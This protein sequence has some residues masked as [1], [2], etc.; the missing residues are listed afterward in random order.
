MR[1]LTN[2]LIGLFVSLNLYGQTITERLVLTD[3]KDSLYLKSTD[4]SFD[5]E[6]N[7][8][9]VIKKNGQEYFVTNND[10][11]GG[12][13]FIVLTFGN[14][15]GVSCTN[16]YSAPQNKPYYYKNDK[17]VKVFGT[18]MEKIECFQTSNTRENIYKIN[19]I[20]HIQT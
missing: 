11:I 10:T 9:F 7:Y 13:K 4:I 12:F 19:N 5:R 6:G 17:G 20:N 3:T 1:N 8:C 15:G 18:A 2:I 16:S 14:G